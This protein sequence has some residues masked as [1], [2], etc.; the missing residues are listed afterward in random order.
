[1]KLRNS[2]F[3][4]LLLLFLVLQFFYPTATYALSPFSGLVLA[5]SKEPPGARVFEVLDG[6]QPYVAGLQT[7][8]IIIE[9]EGQSVNS[10]DAFVK[11][12]KGFEGKEGVALSVKRGNQT[13]S[14]TVGKKPE[15]ALAP[16][17]VKV[18]PEPQQ[19]EAKP[20]EQTQPEA[21]GTTEPPQKDVKTEAPVQEGG[22]KQ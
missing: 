15:P 3:V 14:V 8:D 5:D 7:G 11:V 22:G 21:K 17:E 20:A 10:L 6:S 4:S 16:P 19:A 2:L 9:I 13:L 12:S 18:S 1:M